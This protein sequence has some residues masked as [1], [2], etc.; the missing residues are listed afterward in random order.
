MNITAIKT[1]IVHKGDNLEEI[2]NESLPTLIE[3]SVLVVTSKIV[4]LSEN[5]V[6][7]KNLGTKE[8]K[9]ELVKQQAE[10]YTD[11]NDSPYQLMLTIKDQIL[12]VN[13][14]VDE[15]N[16]EGDYV[17][18]P[19]EPYKSAEKIWQFARQK[20]NLKHL[21]VVITD[22]R[23]FPLKW[24]IIGTCLAHC[25]FKALNNRIGEPDLFGHQM[26]MTQENITEALAVA[27]N[28]VMGEVAEAQP[29]AI[30][31]NVPMVQFQEASPSAE[32][33]QQLK[34]SLQDDAYSPIL[35][36]AAWFKGGAYKG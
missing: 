18:L 21:G 14:G 8:E 22:S 9:W 7:E 31:E 3:E 19:Q 20:Y 36:T 30:I 4:A 2:L 1:R 29:L 10:L 28:L 17:L 24:G 23:T 26:Q 35:K 25:G 15:S 16:A 33:L 34:I 6:V 12:A 32:E 13:S 11:P 27:A 5:A